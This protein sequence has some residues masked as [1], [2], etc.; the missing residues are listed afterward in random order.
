[1][2]VY[3]VAGVS[4]SVIEQNKTKQ[5]K[6]KQNKKAVYGPPNSQ[7]P[8]SPDNSGITCNKRSGTSP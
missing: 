2:Q 3:A 8:L 1:M 6:T 7:I 5:N 4:C